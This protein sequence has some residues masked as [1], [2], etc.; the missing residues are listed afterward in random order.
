MLR[1]M[2]KKAKRRTNREA[3]KVAKQVTSVGV[4]AEVPVTPPAPASLPAASHAA[5]AMDKK[6]KAEAAAEERGEDSDEGSEHEEV[7]EEPTASRDGSAA[8]N[9][10]DSRTLFMGNIPIS[11]TVKSIGAFCAKFGEVHSVRLRSVPV[12]G[13]AVD[14]KG[15]QDLV[16]KVCTNAG[17]FGTQKKCFNAY[18]VFK[19]EASVAKALTANNSLMG[20]R[21]L[22]VDKANPTLFDTRRSVFI[23]GLPHYMDEEALREHFAKVLPGGHADIEGV[24]IVR[25]PETLLCKGFGYML[26]R[27]R[28]HVL[29]VLPLHQQKF[30]SRELRVQ[31]CGKRTKKG[32][33]GETA[34]KPRHSLDGKKGGGSADSSTSNNAPSSASTSTSGKAKAALDPSAEAKNALFALKRMNLKKSGRATTRNKALVDKSQKKAVKGRYGKR[35]GGNVKK[36]MKA[37]KNK[38]KMI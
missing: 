11:E 26:F 29:K 23:G 14:D 35:L 20:K 12:E 31:T 17:K 1:N 15:N 27:D 4:S 19:E 7:P 16:K 38:N 2:E 13:T 5:K 18:V 3:K 33:G 22:R 30:K 6:R 25:D 21:H 36:A 34:K 32:S 8:S 10:N 9:A 24:R 28:D 37:D